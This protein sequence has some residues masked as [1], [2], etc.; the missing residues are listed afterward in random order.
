MNSLGETSS[1]GG[2]KSPAATK[3]SVTVK[4][5]S[6]GE[7]TSNSTGRSSSTEAKSGEEPSVQEDVAEVFELCQSRRGGVYGSEDSYFVVSKNRDPR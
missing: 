5:P 2:R 3:R 7:T 4:R 1:G 6:Y